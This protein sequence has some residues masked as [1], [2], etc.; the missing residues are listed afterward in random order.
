MTARRVLPLALLLG[1]TA[2]G[3]SEAA[4]PDAKVAATASPEAA[5]EPAATGALDEEQ[6]A[7]IA[8]AA[9]PSRGE[10]SGYRKTTRP[11]AEANDPTITRATRCLKVKPTY[12]ARGEQTALLK[13]SN[14]IVVQADVLASTAEAAAYLTALDR[15]GSTCHEEV[16][17]VDRT[18]VKVDYRSTGV[19]LDGADAA[20][21][22]TSTSSNRGT[23]T[24][25][26]TEGFLV[27]AQVGHVVLLV[28]S[29]S[30]G[31]PAVSR[32][33]VLRVAE[34]AIARLR[35]AAA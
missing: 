31:K 20:I 15:R 33:Q 3:G 2:C 28:A 17:R 14:E 21:G 11:P 30:F 9:A 35:K 27:Q 16:A 8:T 24:A 1:L 19:S 23:R 26:A 25:F 12:L 34:K 22:W 7:R 5:A 10:V 4:V 32:S 13:G 18:I 29:Y 6:A